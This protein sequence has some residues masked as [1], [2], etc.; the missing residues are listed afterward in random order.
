MRYLFQYTMDQMQKARIIQ[1]ICDLD[2]DVTKIARQ[3][4][5]LV[6]HNI[7]D[8]DILVILTSNSRYNEVLQIYAGIPDTK[9][10]APA[11]SSGNEWTSAELA[12]YSI[13]IQDSKN[14][15]DIKEHIPEKA[16]RF[17]EINRDFDPSV[18][19]S[20]KVTRE[21]MQRLNND[22]KRSVVFVLSNSAQE[23]CVD[24]MM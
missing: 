6:G 1:S 2:I 21:I 23:S 5:N 9:R 18:I 17:L 19:V 15:C 3:L 24:C 13:I 22:F 8:E 20:N 7:H 4:K 12:Y 14:I 10:R 11:A 16:A